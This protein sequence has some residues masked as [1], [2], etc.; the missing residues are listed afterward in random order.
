MEQFANKIL[1]IT[2][3]YLLALSKNVDVLS[4][5]YQQERMGSLT[6]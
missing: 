4:R 2:P 3:Q 5:Y 1:D 6:Q